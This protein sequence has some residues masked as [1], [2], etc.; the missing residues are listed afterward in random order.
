MHLDRLTRSGRTLAWLA[1]AVMV[2]TSWFSG[3][4]L[5]TMHYGGGCVLLATCGA[6]LMCFTGGWLALRCLGIR[7]VKCRGRSGNA[8]G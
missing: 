3:Q 1:A 4:R 2:A 7:V 8:V 5:H 6:G